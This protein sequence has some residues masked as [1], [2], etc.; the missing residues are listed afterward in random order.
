MLTGINRPNA[1]NDA[2]FVLRVISQ[3]MF[4][5]CPL[6]LVAEA[7]KLG[8]ITHAAIGAP[9]FR[10]QNVINESCPACGVEIFLENGAHAVCGKGHT[11]GMI[12]ASFQSL[13]I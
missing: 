5:G 6:D 2:P 7:K 1:A 11:W 3:S 12:N 13:F 10:L 9:K 4:P 8:D